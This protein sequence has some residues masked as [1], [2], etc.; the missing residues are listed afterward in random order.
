MVQEISGDIKRKWVC[1]NRARQYCPWNRTRPPPSTCLSKSGQDEGLGQPTDL[2]RVP[3]SGGRSALA[4]DA[5]AFSLPGSFRSFIEPFQLSLP[6]GDHH[7]DDIPLF[8]F[9]RI[10]LFLIRC[11]IGHET[12]EKEVHEH[13]QG[14]VPLF[15]D[16]LDVHFPIFCQEFAVIEQKDDWN[17]FLQLQRA[18]I[19]T[20]YGHQNQCGLVFTDFERNFHDS[21]RT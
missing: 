16:A 6:I 15:S 7:A 5:R 13:L 4:P 21:N 1:G 19:A 12:F 10:E 17:R 20:D 11:Y 8:P 3:R 14:I 9:I 18:I 2:D